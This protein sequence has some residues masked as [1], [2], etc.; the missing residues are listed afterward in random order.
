MQNFQVLIGGKAGEGL[1]RAGQVIARVL[2]ALGYWLYLYYD[3]P[4]LIRGGHNF[5]IIRASE[6]RIGAHRRGVDVLIALDQETVRQHRWRLREGGVI[7]FDSGVV[8]TEGIGIPLDRILREEEA[9]PITRN[10]GLIGAFCRTGGVPVELL[11]EVVRREFPKGTDANLRVARRGYDASQEATLIP[12][13]R[14]EGH[15][16][17]SGNEAIGMGLLS[18]GLTSYFAYPMTPTSS[19]LHFMAEVE[20]RFSLKVVHPENEIAV[21]LMAAGAACGGERVAVGTS[22]GGFCLM[23][24]GLGF[25]AISESP[26]VIVLGQRTGPSTGLPTYTSQGDLLFALSAGQGE[27]P[28]LIL[29]P[30][31]ASEAFRW[32]AEALRLAWRFQLPA[33]IL[34]DKTLSE[35]Y[36][37]M[38]EESAGR[39]SERAVAPEW[40]GTGEYRRYAF[41]ENGISPFAPLGTKGA[42]VKVNSYYHDE[43]GI[44][45]EEALT[46]QRMQE[47]LLLKGGALAKALE[48]LRCVAIAGDEAAETAIVCWGSNAGVCSEVAEEAGAR[49]VRPVVLAPFPEREFRKALEGAGRVVLVEQNAT[50][51]LGSILRSRGIPIDASIL[52]YDG[53]PFAVEELAER[54]KEVTA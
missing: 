4:S 41:T 43:H 9:P 38:P 27:F 16:F 8:K 17:V 28:R 46:V 1:N 36:F 30:G 18:A 5:S 11:E 51:Q 32:S 13:G 23:T 47:K 3:Y 31:D 53:R 14:G 7:L 6:R 22:G 26:I 42:V 29:A 21:M 40:D 49:L 45:T 2:N 52:K 20:E 35:G 33:F 50:G 12:R 19:L 15:P 34:S 24:E 48:G 37:S 44:T 54:V 10:S 39:E 25:A